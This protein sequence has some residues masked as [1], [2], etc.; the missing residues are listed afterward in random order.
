FN[1][2]FSFICETTNFTKSTRPLFSPRL[3]QE[4]YF[5][6]HKICLTISKRRDSNKGP[7]MRSRF[8]WVKI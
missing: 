3:L 6:F 8:A 7:K 2:I 4:K 1:N 5:V